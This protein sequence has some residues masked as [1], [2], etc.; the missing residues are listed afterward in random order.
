MDWWINSYTGRRL[1]D[2]LLDEKVGMEPPLPCTCDRIG[3]HECGARWARKYRGDATLRAAATIKTEASNPL[4]G[5]R[6]WD[7]S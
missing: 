1:T 5:T 3:C 7:N 6:L 2:A 4:D